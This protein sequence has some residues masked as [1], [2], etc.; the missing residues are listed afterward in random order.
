MS[1]PFG[2]LGPVAQVST[3]QPESPEEAAVPAIIRRSFV[4]IL[5]APAHQLKAAWL[6]GFFLRQEIKQ[7]LR[8]CAMAGRR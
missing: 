7:L 1:L 4:R 6:H 8:H 3:L 2:L 5:H